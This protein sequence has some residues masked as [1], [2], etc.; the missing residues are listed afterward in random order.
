MEGVR[1]LLEANCGPRV[2]ATANAIEDGIAMVRELRPTVLIVDRALGTHVVLDWLR[3]LRT[4]QSPTTVVVWGN[5][6]TES[7]ALRYV[8]AGAGGVVRKTAPVAVLLTCVS[9]V[10]GGGTWMEEGLLPEVDL[11]VRTGH[12]SL[13]AR[14]AQVLE[15]VER[16]FKNREIAQSLGIQT[17]T[18]KIHLKH[19]F[20]KTGIRGRYGLALNG[21]KQ[22]GLAGVT[23]LEC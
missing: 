3:I 17:G 13:T 18:V 15:L 11:V 1:S 6:I 10:I 16:G 5:A 14:E 8:Q 21:L 22:K 19:I 9:T 20:E 12:S 2:I 7:E 23:T 4:E